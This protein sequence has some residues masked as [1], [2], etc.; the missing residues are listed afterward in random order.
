ML[1]SRTTSLPQLHIYTKPT[2]H[3]PKQSIMLFSSQ[4]LR[5]NFLLW[6]VAS[7][8]HATKPTSLKLLLS[9]IL[10]T[11]RNASSIAQHTHFNCTQ[12][13][14][15]ANY[16]SFSTKARTIPLN[17]GSVLVTL[18]GDFTKTSTKIPSRLNQL[19][20]PLAKFCGIFTRKAI[21]TLS[22]SN[23]KC[24]SKPQ[25]VKEITFLT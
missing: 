24:T 14:S 20:F 21:A 13:P 4:V 2:S 9:P 11:Q 22:S 16:D 23:G 17:F 15:S 19:L 10:F 5:P 8:K 18:S 12:L 3:S 6:D 7:T 25:M 1:A